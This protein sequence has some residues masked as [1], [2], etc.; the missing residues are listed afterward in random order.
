MTTVCIAAP[1]AKY[2]DGGGQVWAYLNWAL[3]FRSLG[4]NVLWL[5]PL[6]T[7]D[8]V[9]AETIIDRQRNRLTPYGLGDDL[10]MGT[11]QDFD[12]E[13]RRFVGHV[14]LPDHLSRV[15]LDLEVVEDADLVVNF[16]YQMPAEW[17]SRF[18]RTALV[19]IDPGLLQGWMRA[20][21]QMV[22]DHDFYV[23]TG[24]TV[25]KT[26][27]KIA[28]TGH[29]WQYIPPCVSLDHWN[30]SP[31]PAEAAYTTVSHWQMGEYEYDGDKVYSNDKRTGFLPFIDL[32]NRTPASLEL[33]LFLSDSDEAEAEEWRARGWSIITSRSVSS[34][35][36]SYRRYIQS[37]RGEFSAVKPSCITLE[38]AWISD[39]TLCYLA[40]GK[41]AVVEHTGPSR[42]LP[43]G[44]GLFRVRDVAEAAKAIDYIEANY[45]EQSQGARA[46]AETHFGA[47]QA[48]ER[49]LE[50]ALK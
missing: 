40:S 2:A 38:N 47:T 31:P 17:L 21:R 16:F 39:R 26:G 23:T 34:T 6:T 9:T 13:L 43:D 29:P 48:A 12:K 36:Q 44:D 30:V 32:P 18:R 35:P 20:N 42:L 37:S 49:M 7:R 24:E 45:T 14:P 4:A 19:D 46:L 22:A 15:V 28:D 11:S 5:E 8:F 33:A 41:P 25:G 3:G 50:I 10:V 1:T 27:S